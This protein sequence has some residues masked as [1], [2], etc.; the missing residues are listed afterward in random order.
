MLAHPEKY[1]IRDKIVTM[2]DAMEYFL[3]ARHGAATA[4]SGLL[5]PPHPDQITGTS[6]IGSDGHRAKA[7]H[8]KG[9]HVD[10]GVGFITRDE[11]DPTT[12]LARQHNVPVWV[13]Q[14]ETTARMMNQGA[15]AG[16]SGRQLSAAAWALF[17]FWRLDYDHTVK[18]GYH[19]LHEVLDIASNFG[20]PYNMLDREEGLR[21][22]SPGS[23]LSGI[24]AWAGHLRQEHPKLARAVH[25]HDSRSAAPAPQLSGVLADLGSRVAG[26]STAAAQY[27]KA[28]TAGQ[29]Q[30]QQAALRQYALLCDDAIRV[31]QHIHQV[32]AAAPPPPQMAAAPAAAG[33]HGN[34]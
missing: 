17:A 21:G 19:T 9:M 11:G 16:A 34:P 8:S 12:T 31:Y 24:E 1:D 32:L 14:S 4:G 13:G 30:E 23:T 26:L 27:R 28:E 20:V 33:A 10:R 2:H 29:R 3:A 18:W 7:V 5:P 22:F 6:E 25:D 15:Y